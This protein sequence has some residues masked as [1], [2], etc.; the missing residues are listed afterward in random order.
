[1]A[2]ATF[3]WTFPAAGRLWIMR[4]EEALEKFGPRS[5]CRNLES[6]GPWRQI[7]RWPRAEEPL[8]LVLWD[9][10]DLQS[11]DPEPY[12]RGCPAP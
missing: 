12:F 10:G 11:F 7:L 9:S 2:K 1:M 6:I 5:G 4:P 3:R 8:R